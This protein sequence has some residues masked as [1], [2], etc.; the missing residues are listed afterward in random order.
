M[1]LATRCRNALAESVSWRAVSMAGATCTRTMYGMHRWEV[2]CVSL[3][4]TLF[5]PLPFYTCPMHK[6]EQCGTVEREREQVL[7][8]CLAE[9]RGPSP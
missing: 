8:L 4:A 5:L 3:L 7:Y 1:E 6:M 2:Y 9:L